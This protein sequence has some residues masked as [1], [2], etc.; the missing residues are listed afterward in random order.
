[1]KRTLARLRTG[2][3]TKGLAPPFTARTTDSASFSILATVLFETASMRAM[4]YPPSSSVA[5]CDARSASVTFPATR[6]NSRR[7]G[8]G[9]RP[10][11]L[12]M[13]WATS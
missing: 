11:I 2:I 7:M 4:A 5:S 8:S 13:A 12:P 6:M 3:S 9:L 1:M 10:T